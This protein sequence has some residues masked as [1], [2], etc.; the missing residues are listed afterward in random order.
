MSLK[1]LIAI[2]A[3]GPALVALVLG[4]SV[5]IAA[6]L[7]EPDANE[8]VVALERGGVGAEKQ[9]DPQNEGRWRI[10][11]SKDEAAAAARVLNQDSLPPPATKG[12]LDALDDSSLI[13]SRAA[14]HAKLVVGTAG[15]LERSLRSVRGVVAARVHLAVP[16][17]GRFETETE[18]EPPTASV[19]LRHR[20]PTPPLSISAVQKLVA[21]AVPGLREQRVAVVTSR[22]QPEPT[23]AGAGL[24][25]F[26]PITITKST[27]PVLRMAVG[28]A[29]GLNLVLLVALVSL[30]SRARRAER[31]GAN[32]VDAQK[33]RS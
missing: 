10:L 29:V 15:E 9:M 27:I 1:R 7:D 8:A 28:I 26:G 6:N 32:G 16:S 24:V 20:G 33:E 12:V 11:V 23:S 5:P 25:R 2:A 22:V 4:C 14:E 13:P 30:W 21:G 18:A 31:A 17:K 3:F 19:L